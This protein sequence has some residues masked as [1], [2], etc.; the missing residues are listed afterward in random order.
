MTFGDSEERA[1]L[2]SR[3]RP[4]GLQ[5]E[6]LP[7]VPLQ[8]VLDQVALLAALRP[9]READLR[10]HVGWQ[11]P[12]RQQVGL[13]IARCG[14]HSQMR[15]RIEV[16]IR[17]RKSRPLGVDGAVTGTCS[18]GAE[19]THRQRASHSDFGSELCRSISPVGNCGGRVKILVG[20]GPQVGRSRDLLSAEGGAG[21]RPRRA[22]TTTSNREVGE[23]DHHDIRDKVHGDALPPSQPASGISGRN[24]DAPA[25]RRRHREQRAGLRG[26]RRSDGEAAPRIARNGV[27]ARP[28][29]AEQ[30]KGPRQLRS[31]YIRSS[32]CTASAMLT[33]ENGGHIIGGATVPQRR[34]Q[35][36]AL[37]AAPPGDGC[38]APPRRRLFPP[39]FASCGASPCGAARD[40]PPDQAGVVRRCASPIAIMS[41]MC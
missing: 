19:C 15:R 36:V 38:C 31:I 29:A 39:P 35:G 6:P 2:V 24:S 25:I 22:A 28:K 27:I 23:H 40:C 37:G 3:G 18:S 13:H 30:A 34:P 4:G 10:Q 33:W 20:K 17:L 5:Q 21:A 16:R 11:P 9:R 32:T 1:L 14:K 8:E 12:S 7:G 41:F 26:A